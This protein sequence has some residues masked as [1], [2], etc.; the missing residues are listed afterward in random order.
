MV[1]AI[2]QCIMGSL[3]GD[4]SS[5]KNMTADKRLFYQDANQSNA[6][7]AEKVHH[8]SSKG[9]AHFGPTILFTKSL[10][11]YELCMCACLFT[12]NNLLRFR[13]SLDTRDSN[14]YVSRAKRTRCYAETA[15]FPRANFV[16]WSMV[17]RLFT[18]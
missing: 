13:L 5:W 8:A 15:T 1:I 16:V 9:R 7:I 4:F 12:L 3:L 14:A 10:S 2:Y 11:F 17:I 18:F 6:F